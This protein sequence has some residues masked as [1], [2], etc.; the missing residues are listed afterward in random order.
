MSV[1]ERSLLWLLA[2]G[3]VA[4]GVAHFVN[5][6]PFVR[7]VPAAL[8]EPLLLVH[9]SGAFEILGGLG[10]LH[11]RTRRPAALGLVALFV[12]VFPANVNMAVHGIQLDPADPMPAWVAWARLP[13]QALFIAWALWLGRRRREPAPP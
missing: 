2:I 11:E 12:A 13:F 4:I 9:V 5:P 3:M 7:I 6:E 8:P 10:L 1:I